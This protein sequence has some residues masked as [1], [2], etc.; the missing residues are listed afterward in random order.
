VTSDSW[1]GEELVE[2][3][4]PETGTRIFVALHSS[5]LGPPTGGTRM[6][7]Y[8]DEESARRDAMRLAE[9]M[10]YK[11]AAADLPR[12][13]GKAVLAVSPALG[14]SAREG[15]LRR[16]GALLAEL[17]GRFY[18]GGDV[19]TSSKDMDVIAETG[20]PYVF[21]RTPQRGGAGGSG[22][23]TALGVFAAIEAACERLF[24][25]PSP[26]GRRAV[27]QGAGSVGAPLIERLVA[28]G[29]HVAAADPD[30][31]AL[32]RLRE[33]L[34]IDEIPADAC[35]AEPCDLFVPC[36]L[37]GILN[38]ETIPRLRARAVVG[39]ANDQ[40][41]GPQDA[42]RLGD[43]GI[44]YAPDF[45]V[46]AGGAVAITG[47]EALGWSAARAEAAVR[48]IGGTLRRVL[49]LADARGMTTDAAARR[50]AE[51]RLR[52]GSGPQASGR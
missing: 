52:R 17:S 37:G 22:S 48:A 29:A 18:T 25:N 13:G 20:A 5:R 2:R 43:R 12:G 15:L 8:P 39:A 47:I 11:W 46:N 10:T 42:A 28:S 24:G 30:G 23:W 32:R 35:F 44:L 33:R 49:D 45:V 3:F 34:G 41:A 7:T 19:G 51:E 26:R 50:L 16:Y 9:A 6:K 36:A 27:V 14:A 40:L 1:S 4:D 21:S 31:P 38:A